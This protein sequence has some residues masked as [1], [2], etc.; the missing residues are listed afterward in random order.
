MHRRSLFLGLAAF[1]ATLGAA[2]A[3]AGEAAETLPDSEGQAQK[4]SIIFVGGKKRAAPQRR[5]ARRRIRR[6]TPVE[7][8]GINPQPLPPKSR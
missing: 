2:P 1:A 7:Q 4:R 3:I 5:V 8:R 6:V